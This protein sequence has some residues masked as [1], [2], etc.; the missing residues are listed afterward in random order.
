M[1]ALT[2]NFGQRQSRPQSLSS[3]DCTSARINAIYTA[4]VRG[5]ISR[6]VS[7]IATSTTTMHVYEMDVTSLDDQWLEAHERRR[8]W[9]DYPTALARLSWKPEFVQALNLSTLASSGR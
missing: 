9:V 2:I 7:T 6:Y 8:E 3:D 1:N 4:G 5:I